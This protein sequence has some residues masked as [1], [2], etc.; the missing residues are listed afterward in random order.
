M[1]IRDDVRL[2]NLRDLIYKISKINNVKEVYIFGSRAY[3]TD[4]LRSDIDILVYAPEGLR[5]DEIMPIIEMEK[6]LDIF[7]TTNKIEAESFANDSWIRRDDIVATLDA[8]LLW[9]KEKGES[10]LMDRY[11]KIKVQRDIDFKMS[12]IPSYS[13]EEIKFYKTYGN[14]AVFVIMP[15]REKLKIVY[16]IIQ[17]VFAKNEYIAIRANEKLFTDDLWNNVKVYLDC[18]K[19]AVAIFDKND[20]D[21]YNPNVALEVGYMLAKGN[22]VCLLKDCKLPKLPSDLISRMYMEYDSDKIETT[23]P[24]QLELWIRDYLS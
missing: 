9:S 8:K 22:K 20:Q 19:V 7:K 5:R 1:A 12:H 11:Q 2:I 23:L 10:S 3:E 15:F 4:S 21:S 18:C 14:H 13:D 24:Q 16:D 17:S 6:A